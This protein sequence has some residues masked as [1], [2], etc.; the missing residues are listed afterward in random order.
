MMPAARQAALVAALRRAA[1]GLDTGAFLRAAADPGRRRALV[2]AL[3]DEVTIRETTFARD[4]RQ[5][6]TIAWP[7]L[8]QGARAAGSRTIRVWSAGCASGEEAYTLALLASEAFASRHAPVDVLGT[9]ISGAALAAAAAGQYRER[10]VHALEAPLRAR[11]LD[12][13]A[14]GSYIVGRHLRA[15]VRFR[16]HNLARDPIPPPGEAGFDLIACR[17]VLIYFGQPLVGRV[18]QSL[19]RS[20]RPGGVLILGAADA[21]QRRGPAPAPPGPRPPGPLPSLLPR[22]PLGRHPAHSREQQLAAALAAA[23]QGDRHGALARVAALLAGDPL[24]ADAHFV[25]GLVLLDSGEPARAAA[26]LRCALYADAAFAL[27][28][29]TLGRAYDALGDGRAARRAYERVLRTLDPEDHSH[30]LIRQHMNVADIAAACR[31]RL[32]ERP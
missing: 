31:V 12:Q 8:L 26:A 5:L 13:Q 15:L 18:I 6:D 1:P 10:A 30:K 24:D 7:S 3:I 22:Q 4:R 23:G 19:E 20:A 14:D 11:Y 16:R 25:R 9:D 28:A 32:G 2:D 17:N 27:A 29:Y 21:L